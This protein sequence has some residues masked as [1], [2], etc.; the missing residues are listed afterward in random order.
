MKKKAT[1]FTGL[2]NVDKNLVGTAV[3]YKKIADI[4]LKEGYEVV[5][6][7]PE[8]TD[9]NFPGVNFELYEE[10]KNKKMINSSSV[11]VFGAY[12]PTRPLIYAYQE[13]KVIM[14]YLWSIAPIGSLEFKDFKKKKDQVD[15]HR[16]ITASYNLSLLFSDKIFCRDSSIRNLVLGSLISLGRLNL[17]N[18]LE[19]K[20]FRNL[21]EEAPF[22]I[23]NKKPD[24]VKNIYRGVYKNIK[25]DDFIL[26]WNGGVWNW[27]DGETLIRAMEKL[28]KERIKLI[29]QGFKHPGKGKKISWKAKKCLDLAKK[30]GLEGENV[31]FTQEWVPYEQRSD[32]LLESDVG[33]VSSPDIPEANLFFKTRVYD[34]FWA[35]LPVILNDCE[36]FAET[37]K[38]KKLG[39]ISKTGD[40]EDWAR[41]IRTLR[42]NKGLRQ[43]IKSNIRKYKKEI[44]WEKTLKPIQEFAQD[45]QK[46]QDKKGF[47][48]P[49]LKK[50]I[51]SN[52]DVVKDI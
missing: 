38:T 2:V 25:E 10:E 49:L 32:F 17:E 19:D 16:F 31:F 29:F 15:L 52:I 18:Y 27:N 21:I 41:N 39:L 6:V 5:M 30:L 44:K 47:S 12:P 7:I 1:I 33:V 23:E 45:P 34:Y 51:D 36:A 8:E 13:N 4:F 14:T 46:V 48:N 20:K 22:G 26:L 40:V 3:I 9:L 11:V 35:E 43:E 42:R 28:K 50:I 37:I 24:S